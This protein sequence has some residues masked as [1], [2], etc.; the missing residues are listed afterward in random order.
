[1]YLI[2]IK[3]EWIKTKEITAKDGEVGLYF[4]INDGIVNKDSHLGIFRYCHK[5]Y[6][7]PL[8][9]NAA[10]SE[11]LSRKVYEKLNHPEAMWYMDNRGEFTVTAIT[12]E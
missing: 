7:Q 12:K 6:K 10:K 9:E 11:T 5:H 3:T 4:T 1:M 2:K 8:E